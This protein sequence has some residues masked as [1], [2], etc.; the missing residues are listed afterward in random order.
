MQCLGKLSTLLR[1]LAPGRSPNDTP[2]LTQL[3]TAA[4]E[5][6]A[7]MEPH[8]LEEE[9]I[10]LPL[11]R[12]WFSEKEAQP[13]LKEIMKTLT[14][15]DLAWYLRQVS[16]CCAHSLGCVAHCCHPCLAHRHCSTPWRRSAA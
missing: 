7:L 5:L 4:A 2:V 1:S 8:L 16:V 15:A 12:H 10:G 3:A 6:Q 11:M 9:A 14:P 13:V